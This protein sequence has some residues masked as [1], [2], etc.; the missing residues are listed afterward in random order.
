MARDTTGK[1]RSRRRA[2]V[3]AVVAK[4][5]VIRSRRHV[6][7]LLAILVVAILAY[8][9]AFR[10]PFMFD[11]EAS[12][13]KNASIRRLWPPSVALEPPRG[14]LAV[15]GRPAVNYSLAVNY[16]INRVLGVD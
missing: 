14:D 12:I 2:A 5:P 10:A 4:P 9:P 8:A 3:P 1:K 15:S 11:D 6:W 16:A 7:L 13:Q